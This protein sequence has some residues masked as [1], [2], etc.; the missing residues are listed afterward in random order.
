VGAGTA[1]EFTVR[2]SEPPISS[3]TSSQARSWTRWW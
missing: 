3:S 1:Q 2:Y